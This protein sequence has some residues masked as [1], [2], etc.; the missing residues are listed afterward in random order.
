MSDMRVEVKRHEGGIVSM[1]VVT[2]DGGVVAGGYFTR[3]G[4]ISLG[5]RG[6]AFVW[7]EQ[8]APPLVS[9]GAVNG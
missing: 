6:I 2:A 3:E 7:A 9:S 4:F 5:T 8:E 1:N